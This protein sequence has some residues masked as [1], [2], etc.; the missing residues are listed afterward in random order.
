M[1]LLLLISTIFLATPSQAITWKE[2]WKPFNH[3]SGVYYYTRPYTNNVCFRNV[4]REQY[5][6][7]NQWSHGYIRRWTERVSVPC[8]H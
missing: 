7:G 2:F 8:Y 1:K 3:G 6:P 4:Y 5:I